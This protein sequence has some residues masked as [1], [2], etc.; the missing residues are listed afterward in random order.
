MITT[1]SNKFNTDKRLIVIFFITALQ[2]DDGACITMIH[3]NPKSL[4]PITGWV[5]AMLTTSSAPDA[6]PC[7]CL[8]FWTLR[9]LSKP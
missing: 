7:F 9:K 1:D 8:S 3:R 5:R 4:Q 6:S 2:H